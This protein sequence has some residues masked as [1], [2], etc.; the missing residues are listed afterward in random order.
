MEDIKKSK[1]GII[2]L[3]IITGG[4]LPWGRPSLICGAAGTGKTLFGIEFIVNGIEDFKEPGVIIS[5]EERVQ[6]LI[7]NVSMLGWDLQKYL[8]EKQLA[9]DYVYIERSEIEETGSFNLDGLF[10]R[11][12]EAV[13]ITGARRILIDTLESL[14]SGFSDQQ[15]LRAEIRRLFKWLKD[16][17]LTAI[18]T[19]EAGENTLTRYGLEEYLSDFVLLL[20]NRV[21]D[22]ASTR[23]MRLVKYRGSRHN[24]DE[25]PF[26]I[27][28]TGFSILPVTEVTLDFDAPEGRFLT[29][30]EKLDD[31]LEGRG[32]YRGSSLLISGSPGSGKTSLTASILDAACRRGE[33]VMFLSFEESKRQIIR[34]TASIGI[35]INQ[36]IEKGL[37]H[38]ENFRVVSYGIETHLI[39]MINNLEREKPSLL[40]IDPISSLASLHLPLESRNL[41]LRVLDYI[42]TKGI[43]SVFTEI[44]CPRDTEAGNMDVSSLMDSWIMLCHREIN[45]YRKKTLSIIKARGLKHSDQI[46]ELVMTNNGIELKSL[47]E[48][49]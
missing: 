22:S 32:F 12:A 31:M 37:F 38:F 33:K 42:R 44:S 6:D 21:R 16:K 2:G 19:A 13:R 10:I 25:F 11:I 48:K 30:I 17:E 29:G 14:F 8:D 26:L 18:V 1:S 20:D 4:G 23:R 46:C 28:D 43:T 9:I 15:I 49:G 24:T 36:W 27:T 41:V 47:N 5:F 7:S 40:V 45:G 3:D 34:N 35:D 39:K